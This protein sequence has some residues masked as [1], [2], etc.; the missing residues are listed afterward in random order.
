MKKL[1]NLKGAKALSRE[2]L[3]S[4]NGGD[5]KAD[6]ESGGGTFTCEGGPWF[7]VCTCSCPNHHGQQNK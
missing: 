1:K 2:Q 5:A 7:Y 6:C 4:I 3:Q